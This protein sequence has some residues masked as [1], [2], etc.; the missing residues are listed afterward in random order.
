M[1]IFHISDEEY[2]CIDIGSR[3]KFLKRPHCITM[4]DHE[5]IGGRCDVCFPGLYDNICIG[6]L[7]GGGAV[8]VALSYLEVR[9]TN[10]RLVLSA[11]KSHCKATNPKGWQ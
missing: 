4:S 11:E 9:T 1:L 3:N 7:V 2:V 8:T 10:I 6:C 5:G